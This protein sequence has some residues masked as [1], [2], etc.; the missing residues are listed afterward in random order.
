MNVMAET[1]SDLGEGSLY[2][3]VDFYGRRLKWDEILGDFGRFWARSFSLFFPLY[4]RPI[5]IYY[6]TYYFTTSLP[7]YCLSGRKGDGYSAHQSNA[8]TAR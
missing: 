6:S 2:S 4:S 8:L 3:L 1:E 5:I 7:Y